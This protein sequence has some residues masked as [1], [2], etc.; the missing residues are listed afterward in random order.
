MNPGISPCRIAT[1]LILRSI[2]STRPQKGRGFFC[3]GKARA[4]TNTEAAATRRSVA[5]N[6]AD[7]ISFQ[8]KCPMKSPEETAICGDRLQQR[9]GKSKLRGDRIS[10]LSGS[11]REPQLQFDMAVA[12]ARIW[13]RT[14]QGSERTERNRL[15]KQRRAE[16]TDRR[17][18][19]HIVQ[20][21]AERG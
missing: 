14:G 2:P 16:V 10:M 3:A 7:D 19:I 1:V 20:G 17:R 9:C 15:T 11:E 18:R 5:N 6:G 8:H 21:I 13:A 12:G 4:A